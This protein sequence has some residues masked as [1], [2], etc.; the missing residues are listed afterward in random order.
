MG[1]DEQA[2]A[3]LAQATGVSNPLRPET[4]DEKMRFLRACADLP[5]VG[6]RHLANLLTSERKQ[7]V[8]NAIRGDDA[9]VCALGA[10]GGTWVCLNM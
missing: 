5:H 9:G 4:P 8:Y 2:I 10:R 7:L 3:A 6:N 1:S